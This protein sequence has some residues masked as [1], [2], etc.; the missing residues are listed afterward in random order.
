MNMCVL[1]HA[2]IYIYIYILRLTLSNIYTNDLDH[3]MIQC[4]SPLISSDEQ[5]EGQIHISKISI[6]VIAGLHRRPNF[7][8]MCSSIVASCFQWFGFIYNS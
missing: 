5:Y 3:G 2:Y 4:C 8:N 1:V 7:V 6:V